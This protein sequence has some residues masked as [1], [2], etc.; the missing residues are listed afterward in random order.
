MVHQDVAARMSQIERLSHLGLCE[1]VR[2]VVVRAKDVVVFAPALLGQE[3]Y[4]VGGGQLLRER[5][6]A[7]SSQSERHSSFEVPSVERADE[8]KLVGHIGVNHI[9]YGLAQFLVVDG[10]DGAVTRG[11]G[12]H[13]GA[14]DGTLA[15]I[16]ESGGDVGLGESVA[17]RVGHVV[18]GGGGIEGEAFELAASDTRHLARVVN[19]VNIID[20]ENIGSIAA[21]GGGAGRHGYHHGFGLN[22]ELR[23]KRYAYILP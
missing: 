11:R 5:E 22:I 18:L 20:K 1:V 12:L 8:V 3:F 23:F 4:L 2:F 6:F 17:A 7:V 9:F 14:G 10:H 21:T 15:Q 13:G 16:G 19:N